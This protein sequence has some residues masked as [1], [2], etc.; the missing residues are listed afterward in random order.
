MGESETSASRLSL[1][2]WEQRSLGK[3]SHGLEG[4]E[5][6]FPSL[7]HEGSGVGCAR[8]HIAHLTIFEYFC[9]R[10]GV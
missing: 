8:A 1:S 3:A 2:V 10:S 7:Y 4:V 5:R 9:P 6:V